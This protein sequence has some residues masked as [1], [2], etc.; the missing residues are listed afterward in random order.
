MKL[1]KEG[2]WNVP[3]TGTISCTTCEAGLL[4]EEA[5]VKPVYN[6]MRYYCVCV[7]CGKDISLNVKDLPLRLKEAVDKKR[8]W[9]TSS[10]DW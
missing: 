7:V 6:E 4:V 10:S 8:K 2:K 5:D 1:I 3:W 9:N